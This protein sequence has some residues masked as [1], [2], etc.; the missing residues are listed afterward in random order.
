MRYRLKCLYPDKNF[1]FTN[2]LPVCKDMKKITVDKIFHVLKTG[3][4]AVSVPGEITGPAALTL[5]KMLSL[6]M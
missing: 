2:T 1:Y 6:S 5:E 3:E 4:N